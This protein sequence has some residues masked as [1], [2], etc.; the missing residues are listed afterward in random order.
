MSKPRS[1]GVSANAGSNTRTATGARGEDRVL[2]ESKTRALRGAK[3][4]LRTS[5]GRKIH[6]VEKAGDKSRDVAGLGRKSHLRAERKT[7]AVTD[8]KRKSLAVLG[9]GRAGSA[10]ATALARAGWRIAAISSRRP[11]DARRLARQCGASTA[12]RDPVRAAAAAEAVLIAVPDREIPALVRVLAASPI[13]ATAA[14]RGVRRVYLHT[15]GASGAEAL[16][17][18]SRCGQSAGSLHPL[19][20]LPLARRAQS[21]GSIDSRRAGPQGRTGIVSFEGA[22]FA[23]D[24]DT[25]ARRLVRALAASLGGHTIPIPSP[26]RAAY[27]LAACFASNYLVTLVA[28]AVDLMVLAGLPRKK[29][30]AGLLPLVRS[31]LA[32]IEA[33]GLPAA[34]TGPVARGDGVTLARHAAVLRRASPGMHKLHSALVLR[35]ARLARAAGWLDRAALMRI[36]RALGEKVSGA[37]VP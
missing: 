21:A 2:A 22:V 19:L 29:A 11:E 7:A 1:N 23:F 9:A 18:L 20:S 37:L 15:S 14:P 6:S 16:A 35:T 36:Q 28:E 4:K 31:T 17:A 27:H 25:R 24:G 30:L 3:G 34:L 5:V 32:N 13:L 10:L 33:A 8:T 26:R 12:G